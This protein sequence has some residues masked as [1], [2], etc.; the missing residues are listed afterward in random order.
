[1]WV[2]WWGDGSMPR[3]KAWQI[4]WTILVWR[5]YV[6]Q[7]TRGTRRRSFPLRIFLGSD[8]DPIFVGDLAPFKVTEADMVIECGYVRYWPKTDIGPNVYSWSS[9]VHSVTTKTWRSL[10]TS[11]RRSIVAVG[12]ILFNSSLVALKF[13]RKDPW[14][15]GQRKTKAP[16]C[17]MVPGD[18]D[19]RHR[20]TRAAA[21][22]KPQHR[23]QGASRRRTPDKAWT[24]RARRPRHLRGKKRLAPRIVCVADHKIDD[25]THPFVLD[26]G[27]TG[28]HSDEMAL[29]A[30][31]IN[32]PAT[33]LLSPFLLPS[34][35]RA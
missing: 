14:V 26:G 18:P 17:F 7:M 11:Q 35:S 28:H 9:M 24:P 33:L 23:R 8:T 10:Q 4:Q 22:G 31:E 29:F 34:A 12:D 15:V 16:I 13:E 20:S 25:R 1:M 32:R 19:G 5:F 3:Q 2:Y 6:G 30:P 27:R 21:R